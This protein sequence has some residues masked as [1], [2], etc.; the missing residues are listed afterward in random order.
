MQLTV[1]NPLLD[2]EIVCGKLKIL[3]CNVPE[4]ELKAL[5]AL[6]AYGYLIERK[7]LMPTFDAMFNTFA[8]RNRVTKDQQRVIRDWFNQGKTSLDYDYLKNSLEK[9]YIDWV[10]KL[11]SDVAQVCLVKL[12]IS[13]LFFILSC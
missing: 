10:G 11:E 3:F 1:N 6:P 13:T 2:D 12:R 7:Y 5:R 9:R 4:A 8:M